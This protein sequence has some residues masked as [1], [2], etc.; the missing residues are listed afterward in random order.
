MRFAGLVARVALAAVYVMLVAVLRPAPA[1]AQGGPV[2]ATGYGEVQGVAEHGVI[3]FKGIPYAAP[4]VGDLRWRAPQPRQRG[5][6]ASRPRV[7]ARLHAGPACRP[8]PAAIRDG[9]SED[10]LTSTSGRPSAEGAQLP[11]M[12]WIHGGGFSFGSGGVEPLRRR[13]DWRTRAPWSSASTIGSAA[14]ASSRIRRWRRRTRAASGNYG[15]LD[16]IAALQWVKRN[17]AAFGGDPEQCH[18]LRRVRRR[19]ERAAR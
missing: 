18:H 8:R 15:L 17:I 14:W 19:Q 13:A 1:V 16:Q 6:R 9:T 3:A 4:P 12:V 5:R 11:V 7:R 10:C 2:V